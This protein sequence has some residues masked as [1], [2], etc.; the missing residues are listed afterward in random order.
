MNQARKSALRDI[1]YDSVDNAMVQSL[2]TQ[3][4]DEN[5]TDSKPGKWPEFKRLLMKVSQPCEDMLV[6]CRYGGIEY[7]NCMDIFS[8]VLT[9]EGL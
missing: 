9:D 8:S 6:Y 7:E 1:P 5:A 2:C 3:N 4:I